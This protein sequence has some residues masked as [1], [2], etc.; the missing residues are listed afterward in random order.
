MS[1]ICRTIEQ[2]FEAGFNEA[3]EHGTQP[4]HCSHCR[5]TDAEIGRLV[6]LLRGAQKPQAQDAKT[7]A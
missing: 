6:V 7:A 5:L 2:A 3:C 4:G 1:R